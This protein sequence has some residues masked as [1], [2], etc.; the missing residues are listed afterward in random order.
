MGVTLVMAVFYKP[1]SCLHPFSIFTV[2]DWFA[3]MTWP[4][5]YRLLL[6][7]V[8]TNECIL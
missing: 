4:R 8:F 1:T 7:L 5:F 2:L 6:V 3:T